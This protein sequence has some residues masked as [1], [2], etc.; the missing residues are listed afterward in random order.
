MKKY[1]LLLI[2]LSMLSL[3]ILQSGCVSP[4]LVDYDRTAASKFE[5]YLCFSIDSHGARSDLQD[6]PLSPIVDRRIE[7]AIELTLLSKGFSNSCSEVD[8]RVSFATVSKTKTRAIN[9]GVQ[10]SPF[11]RYSHLRY[12]SYSRVGLEQYEEGT[13]II[14]IIDQLSNQL[15]WRGS[16][17]KRLG[18][19][20]PSD[21]EVLKIVEKIL[22]AF[23]PTGE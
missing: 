4:N 12:G 17:T 21:E 9:L 11:R 2:V 7:K 5:D 1:F 20:A 23:P 16:Y 13:F 3:C 15:V 10:L 18:W 14:D 22:G 6:L 8:F 19:N